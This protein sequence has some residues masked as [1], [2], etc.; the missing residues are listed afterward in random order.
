MR[1]AKGFDDYWKEEVAVIGQFA[2]IWDLLLPK[3]YP[4]PDVGDI[5]PTPNG[6]P[7][8]IIRLMKDNT[9]TRDIARLE[10]LAYPKAEE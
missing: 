1:D 6:P 9:E 2:E 8:K 3:G 5:I 10:I 4:M 7:V